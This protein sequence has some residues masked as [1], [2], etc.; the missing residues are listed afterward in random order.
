MFKKIKESFSVEKLWLKLLIGIV[1]IIVP[2]FAVAFLYSSSSTCSNTLDC[3][4]F[5]L[6]VISGGIILF[7]LP[8]VAVLFI[9]EIIKKIGEKQ[10]GQEEYRLKE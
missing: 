2:I 5:E 10:R 3:L 4:E 1:V 8:I 7:S 6:L 9:W